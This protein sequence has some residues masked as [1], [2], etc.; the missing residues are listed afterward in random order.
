MFSYFFP[1]DKFLKGKLLEQFIL[2]MFLLYKDFDPLSYI[3]LI[4]SPNLLALELQSKGP[5]KALLHVLII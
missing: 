3:F 5:L 4:F 2:E 1:L